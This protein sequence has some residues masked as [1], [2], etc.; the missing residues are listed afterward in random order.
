MSIDDCSVLLTLLSCPSTIAMSCHQRVDAAFVLLTRL[1]CPSTMAINVMSSTSGHNFVLLTPLL[2]C[3][4]SLFSPL[5]GTRSMGEQQRDAALWTSQESN[6][7]VNVEDVDGAQWESHPSHVSEG[8]MD[9]GSTKLLS[10][11][12]PPDMD[13]SWGQDDSEDDSPYIPGTR[14]SNEH[15]NNDN[16]TSRNN[17][18]KKNKDTHGYDHMGTNEKAASALPSHRGRSKL[19]QNLEGEGDR[20]L[21][22]PSRNTAQDSNKRSRD[23]GSSTSAHVKRTLIL[24]PKESKE[25]KENNDP[26]RPW[27]GAD[28][29]AIINEMTQKEKSRNHV[30]LTATTRQASKDRDDHQDGYSS[31]D[32]NASVDSLPVVHRGK[33][34][35]SEQTKQGKLTID[36]PV[37]SASAKAFQSNRQAFQQQRLKR[38]NKAGIDINVHDHHSS[39]EKADAPTTAPT[40]SPSNIP[41]PSTSRNSHGTRHHAQVTWRV[42]CHTCLSNTKWLSFFFFC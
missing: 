23:A 36:P 19:L 28:P 9:I 30:A 29:G 7:W 12:T 21:S 13:G 35:K 26:N 20:P 39:D 6:A 2:S 3:P 32:S 38:S 27:R 33:G 10:D 8:N 34:P 25:N 24:A 16:T 4:S 14:P 41:T 22:S 17:D 37:V 15:N 1:S 11:E 18:T 31:E 40:K 42:V 5:P